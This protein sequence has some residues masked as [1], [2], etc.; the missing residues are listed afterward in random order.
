MLVPPSAIL[1]TRIREITMN[2]TELLAAEMT[3]TYQSTAKII[4][5]LEDSDL[6]WKPATGENWMN[7]G[8][9]LAHINTACGFCCQG[10]V[11]GD[12][13]MIGGEAESPSES[14][15]MM[16]TAERMPAVANLAEARK[17]LAADRKLALQM[18]KEAGEEKMAT[19]EMAAPWE[20]DRQRLL[21]QHMLQMVTHLAIHKAQLFYYLK[22]M[23]KKVDTATL[24]GI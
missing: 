15:G 21:G 23:G 5:L 20:P 18:I 22:L 11:T 19:L 7:V 17:N 24:W 8:Q 16:P 3:E 12:W 14:E 6:E 13:G 10:F 4:D 9:L 1:K 2:W